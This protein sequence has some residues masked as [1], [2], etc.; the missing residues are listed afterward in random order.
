MAS[1]DTER[2]PDPD[3]LLAAAA[4][5][6]HGRL[7]IFLGAAP[8]V[9]KTWEMLAAARQ[10]RDEGVDVL[11]G[12]IETHGRA[13]TAAQLGDL[14]VLPRRQVP[15]RG[16][17]LEEFDLEAAIARRPG[18]LLVDELA[19]TNAPGLRHTKRWQDVADV[20]EAGIDVWTT[21]NVQHLESLNDQV[22][23]ITGVR[24]A[25]TLPDTVLGL[26]SEIE[27]IDLPPAEL[28]VRLEQGRIYRPDLARR[29]LD[30]F[31]RHGNLASLREM[32]LRR[33]AQHVDRDI[34]SYMRSRA[35]TGP[36][37]AAERVMA[38]VETGPAAEQ[39]VRYAARLADALRA[40]LLAFHGETEGGGG[41]QS[42]LDLT[43]QLGGTVETSTNADAVTA[44]LDVASRQ[45]VA[46]IVV[47]RGPAGFWRPR[48]LAARL[49]RRA[50]A[51]SVYV[52]PDPAARPAG[53]KLARPRQPLLPYV[54]SLCVM[55]LATMLGF[56]L[57]SYVP[58]D[59]MGFV[60]TGIVVGVASRYG[61][62]HGLFAAVTSFLL[63]NFFFLPP[64]FTLSVGDP[65][66]VVALVV[67]LAVGLLTGTLA[68]RV[69]IEAEA[70]RS[71]ID[72]LRRVALFGRT[73]AQAI[74]ETSLR[75]AIETEAAAMADH[76]V[77]L[78]AKNNTLTI[79]NQLDEPAQAA[80]EFAYANRVATGAGTITLPSVPWRFL[81]LAT[82]A[83]VIG[84]LG[85]QPASP[86]TEPLAQALNAL[87]DQA[88]MATERL[89][90]AARAAEANAQEATQKLRT[91][92]LS[93]IS[94]DLRTPLT[95]IRGAAETLAV[96][97]LTDATRTDLLA[98]IVQ[99][100]GR[101]TRFLANITG[102]ARIET[103][104]IVARRETVDLSSVIEAA[105]ARVPEAFYAAANLAEGA[106]TAQADPALLE[107]VIVNLL[108]NAIK[109][110]P[111]GAAI[112]IRA[113]RETNTIAI[114]VADE[115][116]GI[117]AA[118]LPHVFDSFF[119]ASR[120]D[121]IAPG[122]GLG[123]AIARAFVEAMNG[124]ITAISPRPDLPRDGLPGTIITISLPC[125]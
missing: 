83:G 80:A 120:G 63:W 47:A 43:I 71:R 15:Y 72:A 99:D 92:L 40:P 17:V 13:E 124:T 2:R 19:H 89:R 101:M 90:L 119:R 9:G 108:E 38:V 3:A 27:L 62:R 37:P 100:V 41:V 53:P 36:W 59:A 20:L 117:D 28:R 97:N 77:V 56:L 116:I 98:S 85:V 75:T 69:R 46:H 84:V 66:D 4:S 39:V 125:P 31:F 112:T 70:A 57:R 91:A 68:G 106:T 64:L 86:I 25:E 60:F 113:T 52:V 5:E 109:Y 45:N 8:G 107:Q 118:D 1:Q 93:S 95:G 105:V 96:P 104:E 30:G 121:R 87:A 123:L 42:A 29:A 67:F 6:H 73:L 51:Y 48:P 23:R 33:V 122:T 81:P 7:K 102:M 16:H 65:R 115:G 32:A 110:A 111:D 21:L 88:A 103:G 44:A 12:L 50:R 82:E 14:T 54:I 34:A 79:A 22:A 94:H 24:V 74:D 49:G 18:L 61:R 35:I 114:S 55:A 10:K 58:H 26:A 11:A 78:M 76:A